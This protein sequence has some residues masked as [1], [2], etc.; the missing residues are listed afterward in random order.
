MVRCRPTHISWLMFALVIAVLSLRVELTPPLCL[1]S[2]SNSVKPIEYAA[3][4]YFTRDVFQPHNVHRNFILTQ[5]SSD[6]RCFRYRDIKLDHQTKL[7]HYTMKR[8]LS[9]KRNR[10]GLLSWM[11][12]RTDDQQYRILLIELNWWGSETFRPPIVHFLWST[13]K[14][15]ERREL[16]H[17]P[18]THHS[19]H[20]RQTLAS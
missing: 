9:W 2:Y 15:G 5:E 20:R 1:V 6:N 16:Q 14:R 8:H 10:I 3:M 12:I 13:S 11:R 7:H 4:F 18:T 19:D 17:M